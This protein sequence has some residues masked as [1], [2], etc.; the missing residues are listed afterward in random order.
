MI[1][2]VVGAIAPRSPH[3][4]PYNYS[5]GICYWLGHHIWT[6]YSPLWTKNCF[7]ASI[8]PPPPPKKK[9]TGK[10]QNGM[11]NENVCFKIN[12]MLHSHW[13][14]GV[15]RYFQCAFNCFFPYFL[16]FS[17]E[18]WYIQRS[19]NSTS[20]LNV[21]IF[22]ILMDS[23]AC[24]TTDNWEWLLG[25]AWNWLSPVSWGRAIPFSNLII[26]ISIWIEPSQTWYDLL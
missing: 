17:T 19:L 3:L 5:L 8:Y 16:T 26:A 7:L 12:L 6:L 15:A 14:Y 22:F 24:V 13:D 1:N 2:G 18:Y 23:P 10:K 11:K 21:S 20:H 9:C 4:A 25:V